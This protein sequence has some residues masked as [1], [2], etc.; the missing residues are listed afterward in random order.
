LA[1]KNFPHQVNKLKRFAGG[2]RVFAEL[3][4]G[5][6]DLADDGVVGDALARAGVY[7]FRDEYDPANIEE[8]LE[9]E[10][11][12]PASN[13]GTRTMARELRRTFLLLGLISETAA[14]FEVSDEARSLITL[15]H[16]PLSPEARAMWQ[17]AFRELELTDES[18]TSHP[19]ELMLRLVGE[20][21]GIETALLGLAL[22]PTNDS[23]AEF[24][25]VL[26]LV[27]RDSGDP[28][29][30][31]LGVSVHQRRNSVKILPAVAR[32]LGDIEVHDQRAYLS[33]PD[34]TAPRAERERRQRRVI[35]SR[36]RR[37]DRN[38]SRGRRPQTSGTTLRTYDPDLL[39]AR[40]AAHEACLAAFD[41]LLSEGFVRWEGDF[42][43]L[44]VDE[45]DLL[46]AE[47]KTIRLDA[48]AQTRVGLGQLL[49][50]EFF[51]I[52]P[53]W[54][55]LPIHRL[56]VLDAPI[57]DELIGFLDQHEVGVVWRVGEAAWDATDRARAQLRH[58]G[59]DL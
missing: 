51:D 22:E 58:F 17:A 8:L 6:A 38:R 29:W 13:Q 59:V 19:Y 35:R 5:G 25:R 42:D 10:H 46:L 55:D 37:Y 4:D 57:D 20:R 15:E 56:V 9:E 24:R 47:V 26:D 49:Y 53:E 43:L 41:A 40:Y 2:L 33:L 39:A 30:D 45:A 16:D 3:R 31:R 1:V 11:A 48:H 12:K 54:P 14:G 50:Y 23:E 32:Q 27:D 18:G 52:R 28:A 44:V 7:T 34:P 36:R 21:P